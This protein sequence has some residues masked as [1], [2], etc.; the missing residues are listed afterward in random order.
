[1]KS[2]TNSAL[3]DPRPKLQLCTSYAQFSPLN[4]YFI[5][6]SLSLSLSLRLLYLLLFI[7]RMLNRQAPDIKIITN[8]NNNID[9]FIHSL[10]S[11]PSISS[12]KD[13]T[14]HKAPI[15]PNSSS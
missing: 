11:P 3:S 8:S 15:N 14:Y 1:M 6:V 5:R 13:K 9:L 2:S 7:P 10:I 12:R 4:T